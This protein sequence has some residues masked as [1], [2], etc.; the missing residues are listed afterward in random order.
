MIYVSKEESII[1]IVGSK[2]ECLSDLY[3]LFKGYIRSGVS[4]YE[5]VEMISD[6]VAAVGWVGDEDDQSE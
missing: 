1:K 3:N 4:P 2:D 6:A 5:I